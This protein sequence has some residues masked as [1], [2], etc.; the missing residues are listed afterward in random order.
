MVPGGAGYPP[1]YCLLTG[2]NGA[3][4]N[5]VIVQQRLNSIE[6]KLTFHVLSLT[7]LFGL[8]FSGLQIGVDY[9][10]EKQR[11]LTETHDL[12]NRQQGPAALALYNYDNAA[13]ESILDSLLLNVAAVASRVE[14]TNSGYVRHAGF[15][16]ALLQDEQQAMYFRRHSIPLLEPGTYSDTPRRIGTLYL[17]SDDRLSR[18]GFNRRAAVTLLL[19]VLRYSVLA[20]VLALLLRARI[21][22]PVRRLMRLLVNLDPRS[23][24]RLP[25][26]DQRLR[27]TE[28]DEL[29]SKM[30]AL[31]RQMQ[32]EVQQRQ[33]AEGRVRFMNEQLEEKVRARTHQLQHS[34]D[35]LRCTQDLLLQAQ[36]MASLGHLA[37]GIAHEINNPIAVVYSNIATLG[38]YLAELLQLTDEYELA[39]RLIADEQLLESLF[40][41][42]NS[43]D[44]D[45]V[46]SDA[47]ELVRNTRQSLDRVRNIVRELR[48]FADSDQQPK[49]R[50]AVALLVQEAVQELDLQ[51]DKRFRLVSLLDGLPELEC[52][53]TQVRLVFRHIL[54]NARDAMP[55]GGTIEIAGEHE[56]GWLAVMIKDNGVG[57]NA[58]DLSCAVNPF[59]T[60][61]EIGKGTGL[62]LTVA[63]NI[64][65]HHGGDL[66]IDSTPGKGTVVTLRFPCADTGLTVAARERLV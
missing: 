32:Q 25:K 23:A 8:V 33:E 15:S 11:F 29:V 27:G 21:T 64:M 46:R 65:Q 45:Y 13:L 35:E 5:G 60:R 48:T 42:R 26:V 3:T 34:L 36:R 22:T 40:R 47:P 20:L 49:E 1:L 56:A 10:N 44:L 12:L 55:D 2:C 59:F 31:L 24:E 19:D 16:P 50:V 6:S 18:P 66:L 54:D 63:Y 61:K 43:I 14:E 38:E 52:V 57:M 58:A 62:G 7:I 9:Y 28:L 4:N 30:N 17:W 41:L 37:A 39:E 51:Q 53:G